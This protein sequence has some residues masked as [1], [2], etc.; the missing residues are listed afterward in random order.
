M[1]VSG[2]AVRIGDKVSC[3]DTVAEGSS[4]VHA[5]GMPVSHQGK[6]KTTGH[7]CFPSTILIGPWSST[8]FINNQPVS[9]KDETKIQAHRCGRSAHDGTVT[10]A[11]STVFIEK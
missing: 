5:D 10:T 9:L 4:N 3:G 8:V 7:G 6:K 2:N 11:S 1:I